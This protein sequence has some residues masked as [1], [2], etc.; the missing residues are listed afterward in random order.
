MLTGGMALHKPS[1]SQAGKNSRIMLLFIEQILN[2]LQLGV[3]LFLVSAGLT[4]IFGIMGVINLAHG[5]LYMIGAYTC[6]TVSMASGSYWLGFLA[7]G[8]AAALAGALMEVI[9][10]RRLYRRDH[11]DQ[12]LV[13]F[14]LI[15]FVNEAVTMIWGRTPLFMDLPQSLSGSVEIVPGAPYPVYRLGVILAGLA[16]AVGLWFL[17]SKTR[18]GMLIR[19]GS[20]NREMVSALG[21]DI[22]RLYTLLFAAG[23]VLAGLAG[24]FAGPLVSVQVGMGES[25]L[26]LAF[27]VVVIG[28][29][30]SVRGALVGAILVGLV[31]TL[32]RAFLRDFLGL[33]LPPAEAAGMGAAL[34]S[35]GIYIV[36]AL[37]LVIRPKGLF[38]VVAG[39]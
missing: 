20:T 23:A 35:M 17:I 7:A 19:A 18:I 34:S 14:G 24:A 5:S 25:I 33:F 21:V 6:A 30:G 1:R 11:L 22:D 2:G 29:I 12:V 39:R 38:P 3:F 9:L 28:G 32:G 27:V 8:L 4:L 13:T 31:D 37:I 36:M 15:L 10:M 16:G 26:I